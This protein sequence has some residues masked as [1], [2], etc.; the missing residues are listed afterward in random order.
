MATSISR[1]IFSIYIISEAE[2]KLGTESHS[3]F[4]NVNL[5]K[6][7]HARCG[8]HRWRR[9]TPPCLPGAA[10]SKWGCAPTWP[11]R[12]GCSCARPGGGQ[13]PAMASRISARMA[14]KPPFSCAGVNAVPTAPQPVCPMTTTKGVSRCST[15]YSTLPRAKSL[16][17]LPALRMMNSSPMPA[18]KM[19][20][21]GTRESLQQTMT[22]RGD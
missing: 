7:P 16:M 17:R 5:A 3:Q 18:W 15:A 21:G 1:N 8:C 13:T 6:S 12:G 20:S 2:E 10:P 19:C 4:S 22:A 11:G 9:R 14:A